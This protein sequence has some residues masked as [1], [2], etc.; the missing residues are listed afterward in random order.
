MSL[1]N[2]KKAKHVRKEN[3][4]SNLQGRVFVNIAV[5]PDLAYDFD[6]V[7]DS[8]NLTRCEVIRMLMVY[9]CDAKNSKGQPI[10]LDVLSKFNESLV[11]ED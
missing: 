7:C 11:K 2:I 8:V 6:Q 3:P 4:A 10:I 9:A 5:R 1:K